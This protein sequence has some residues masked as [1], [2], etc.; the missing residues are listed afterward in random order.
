MQ[1]E[2][3]SYHTIWFDDNVKEIKIIDQ[4]WLP[5]QWEIMALTS[6]DELIEAIRDMAVRGAPLIGVTAAFGVWLICKESANKK[7]PNLYFEKQILA[8]RAAR[9]TAVNLNWAVNHQLE[10]IQHGSSWEEKMT[11]SLAGAKSIKQKEIITCEKIGDWGLEIIQKMYEKKQEPIQILTHCNAGWMACVDW[12]TATAPIY[13]AAKAGIPVHVWV[14]ETRPRN[15]GAAITAWELGNENIPYTIIA[16]NTGGYLMQKGE[17]DLCIVGSDRTAV[18]GDVANKIG[19]YLKALAA[20]DNHVPF[21]VALPSSTID[22]NME[23]GMNEIPI[24]ERAAQEVLFIKGK[25]EDKLLEVQL[26]PDDAHAKNYAF[27]VTPARLVTAL[28][29]ERGICKPSKEDILSMYPENR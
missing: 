12:G 13:K 4:R 3:T 28:I 26:A 17:V 1:I 8:L 16:D 14:D 21:Y 23:N 27:D 25:H 10:I 15:Q 29:T 19:T 11:T 18:N 7:S 9:P 22:F 2:G 6:S 5:H 20:K 24:E